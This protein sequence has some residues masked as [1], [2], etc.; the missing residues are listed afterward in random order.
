MRFLLYLYVHSYPMSRHN[1]WFHAAIEPFDFAFWSFTGLIEICVVCTRLNP[2]IISGTVNFLF[3]FL[4]SGV[5]RPPWNSG[6]T[7]HDYLYPAKTGVFCNSFYIRSKFDISTHIK[8][9]SEIKPICL[10]TKFQFQLG[11][12]IHFECKN[13]Q[14]NIRQ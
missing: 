5:Y 3:R 11:I 1:N 7:L 14:S 8:S 12:I 4:I 13:L 9:C 2:V 6:Y 10:I